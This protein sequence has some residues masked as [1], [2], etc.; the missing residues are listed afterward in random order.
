MSITATAGEFG[1]IELRLRDRTIVLSPGAAQK[2]ARDLT[3]AVESSHDRREAAR[4]EW[5]IK[6]GYSAL[7]RQQFEGEE[8]C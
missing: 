6:L 5:A 2:L 1:E 3:A 8:K 4:H 7:L